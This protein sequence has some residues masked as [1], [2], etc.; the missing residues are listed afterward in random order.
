MSLDSKMFVTCNKDDVISIGNSVT[1]VLNTYVRGK[2]DSYWRYNT[3]CSNRLQFLFDKSLEEHS[4]KFTNGVSVIT[5]NF[6]TFVISFGNGDESRR[7]LFMFPTCSSDYSDVCEGYKVI[8]SIGYW[9]SSEEIMSVLSGALKP[10][11]DVYYDF[12][13]C[14]DEYF[15]KL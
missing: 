11:G 4:R 5:H 8:F 1:E 9:G 7:S 15:I 6:D 10:Y 12:N 2:L 3:T 14:D 13:D